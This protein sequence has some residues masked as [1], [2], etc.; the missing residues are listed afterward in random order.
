MEI[1]R[2]PPGKAAEVEK[3]IGILAQRQSERELTRGASRISEDVFS[4]VWNNDD[5][6]D[7]RR[8]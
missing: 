7:Y 4:K 8:P 5:G 3:S 2:L 6:A 1:K